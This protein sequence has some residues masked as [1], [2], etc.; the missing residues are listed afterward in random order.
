[1]RIFWIA[2]YLFLAT[3]FLILV[4]TVRSAEDTTRYLGTITSAMFFVLAAQHIKGLINDRIDEEFP[5]GCLVRSC[6]H[7][8]MRRGNYW[9]SATG[10]GTRFIPMWV[11][12]RKNRMTNETR[13]LKP[14]ITISDRD[15]EFAEMERKLA[16]YDAL[17]ELQHKRVLEADKEWQRATGQHDV[18]PDLGTLIEWLMADRKR[19]DKLEKQL[20]KLRHHWFNRFL[21]NTVQSGIR[22]AIDALPEVK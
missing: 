2:A 10:C 20:W 8:L 18:M 22:S 11:P 19:L 21:L 15:T 14:K 4:M 16:E 13:Q 3:M 12:P 17:F 9:P 1:M 5:Y 6:N 7:G